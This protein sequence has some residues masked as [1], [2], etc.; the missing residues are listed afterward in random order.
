MDARVKQDLPYQRRK[1]KWTDVQTEDGPFLQQPEA[2]RSGQKEEESKEAA[3]GKQRGLLAKQQQQQ[4]QAVRLA[5][6]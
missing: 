1:Y 5:Q 4:Q 6:N 3:E 2:K